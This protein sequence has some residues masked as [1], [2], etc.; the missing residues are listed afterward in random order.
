MNILEVLSKEIDKNDWTLD[1]KAYYLYLR[2][3]LLFSYDPRY[4]FYEK[5]FKDESMLNS[6]RSTVID[7]ENVENN[8][9]VCSSH[10]KVISDVLYKLLGIKS[11]NQ[12]KGHSW[13]EFND[14]I[15]EIEADSTIYSD[16]SRVQMGL[17]T[18]GYTS[19]SGDYGFSDKLKYMAGKV[20]YIEE[21]YASYFIKAKA[22]NIYDEFLNYIEPN[23]PTFFEYN[24]YKLYE[25]KGLYEKFNL[26]NFTEKDF[27]I[28]YLLRKF[29]NNELAMNVISLFDNRDINNWKFVNIYVFDMVE[30]VIY[31]ILDENGFYQICE[32]DVINYIRNYE[33]INK[34][35]MRK[36]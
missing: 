31:F 33:G 27:C 35:I 8:Y 20:G 10:S 32:Q 9:V 17:N 22:N 25:I 19:R 28:D 29:F 16:I 12:G 36:R 7:V 15:R 18:L 5:F 13:V 6:I 4:K 24:M 34:K 1:E 2:S 23:E 30:E 3:C 11:Q 21:E 14:G 26:N